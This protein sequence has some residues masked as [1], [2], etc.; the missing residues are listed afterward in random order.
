[1]TG[2]SNFNEV[3]FDDVR[4]DDAN[5]LGQPGQGWKV[6]MTTLMNERFASATVDPGPAGIDELVQLAHSRGLGSDPVTRQRL[7][8]LY[9]L[10]QTYR[11]S[12]YRALTA[13]SKGEGPGPEGSIGKLALG[14]ILS[15]ISNVG[16]ALAGPAGTL[17]NQWTDLLLSSP[18]MRIGGGTD[19]VMRNILG[20]RILGL[21]GEPRIDRDLPFADQPTNVTRSTA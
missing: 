20:E 15:A 6:V 9:I 5:R 1:M 13:I 16:V 14:R 18:G 21:P 4:V 17:D 3:F 12:N 8:E 10:L 7:I 19:E 2:G 11:Y